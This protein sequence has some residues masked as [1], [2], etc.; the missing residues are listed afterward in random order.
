MGIKMKESKSGLLYKVWNILMPLM[1]YYSVYMV[2]FFLLSY[3]YQTIVGKSGAGIAAFLQKQ[4]ITL[5]GVVNG[6]SMLSGALVL[7]PM[8]RAELQEHRGRITSCGQQDVF[9]QKDTFRQKDAFKQKSGCQSSQG[10]EKK[11]QKG[12]I[13]IEGGFDERKPAA[14]TIGIILITVLLAGSSSVG[15]NVLLSLTGLVQNSASYQDVARSQYGVAFGVGVV[16]YAV[17]SP[18]AEEIVFRGIIYNRM[19][20]YLGEWQDKRVQDGRAEQQAPG[21]VKRQASGSVKQQMAE[22]GKRSGNGRFDIAVTIAV[23]AS[24]VLFGVYHGNLVQGVYG[25]CMGILLA[26]LYERTHAFYI[27]CLFHATANCVV[28]VL[29]Q[30]PALHE[31]IFTFP[32]C[33]GLL[34]ISVVMIL[35]VEKGW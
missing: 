4:K 12:S 25:G 2:S 18:V 31:R 7:V 19:R 35:I 13:R 30:N 32:W 27:P 20:R 29:A 22:P 3:L 34:A 15:L 26:Y 23:I 14:Q 5:T 28:Y 21:S 1:V 24:G 9:R 6:I 10:E 33:V 17:V 11:Q 8:L 16:L